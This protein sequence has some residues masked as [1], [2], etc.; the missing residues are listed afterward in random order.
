M[1][2]QRIGNEAH[3]THTHT[4]DRSTAVKISMTT[5]LTD[6]AAAASF[7]LPEGSTTNG[8][9]HVRTLLVARHAG[10]ELDEVP[11]D[12]WTMLKAHLD[13]KAATSQLFPAPGDAG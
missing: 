4:D 5:P 6:I 1:F 3:A 11:R 13:E 2:I 7:E 8:W 12:F 10:K 9:G